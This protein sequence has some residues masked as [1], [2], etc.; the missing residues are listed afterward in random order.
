MFQAELG[1]EF[2]R[3]NKRFLVSQ[4]D[5]F[6]C[7]DGTDGGAKTAEAYEGCQYNVYRFHLYHLA[8]GICSGIDLYWF[9]GK[10]FPYIV[11]LALVGNDNATRLVLLCLLDK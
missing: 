7:F 3:H 8:K 9:V 6:A 5:G 1:D 4:S 10:S 11:V 2:A